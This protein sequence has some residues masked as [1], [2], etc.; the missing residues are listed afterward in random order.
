[1]IT[2]EN[3]KKSIEKADSIAIICHV[4]PDCDTVGSGLALYS[5]LNKLGKSKVDILCED[6]CK[7]LDFL[8]DVEINSSD[9]DYVYDLAIAVD[10]A[11]GERMGDM[12]K[13]Y[14]RAKER[15]AI[16]HHKSN[17]FDSGELY[18]LTEVSSCAEIMYSVLKYLSEELID[19]EIAEFLY[20]GIL[21]D[22]GGFYHS[23]T[24]A[25]T[26]ATL[27]ELY[28]YGIDANKIYYELFK[29]VRLNTF[30][31]HSL[32]LSKVNFYEENSIGIITFSLEDFNKTGTDYSS[33]EGCIN[34]LLD[35]DEVKIAISIA[36]V[37]HN[38]YKIS[39]RSKGSIDVSLCAS[40]YGGGGHTNAAG[41]RLN[42]SYYDILDKLLYSAKS[43][44]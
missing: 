35:V 17:E 23:S 38:S 15:F 34:K 39:F 8:T 27:A 30:K 7:K 1:M 19:K 26:H 14:Y 13:H 5:F 28:G 11:S 22:S 37:E 12:R 20:A 4:S 25:G 9:F 44:L 40:R 32:A 21:T 36:E 31:L 43:V 10:V 24:T 41:C 18:L 42:G 16:D 3:I 29:K 2:L 6:E 33:T